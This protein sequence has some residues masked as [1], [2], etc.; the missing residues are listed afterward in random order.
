MVVIGAPFVAWVW[1]WMVVKGKT[2][3]AAA[4]ATNWRRER[5]LIL[6]IV[7]LFLPGK[8]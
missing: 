1:A 5:G 3:V 8:L 2:A 6:G 7:V 4:D